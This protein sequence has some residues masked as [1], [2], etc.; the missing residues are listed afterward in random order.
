MINKKAF[1][2]VSI[3][4]DSIELC[5]KAS[6]AVAA[7]VDVEVQVGVPST[8]AFRDQG[9]TEIVIK[10]GYQPRLL[11]AAIN[12]DE[13]KKYSDIGLSRGIC[14]G[15]RC[16]TLKSTELV[17]DSWWRRRTKPETK[18]ICNGVRCDTLKSTEL[19]SDSWWRRRT[20]PETKP[21]ILILAD[22]HGRSFGE[23][24]R[25]LHRFRHYDITSFYILILADS[26]GRS[27]G[28]A[29]RGL[30]RFRHYD[31][32]SFYKPGADLEDVVSDLESLASDF[33]RDDCVVI[34]GGSNTNNA[35]KG[36]NFHEN[37]LLHLKRLSYVTN[38]IVV[39]TRE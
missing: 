15:V 39:S 28:E 38:V 7:A 26:H 20:K 32:T 23:A 10:C 29:V 37:R 5:D 8:N 1:S 27:F 14:N 21:R 24:V 31:I 25:G 11:N 16:D 3:Q 19:V 13:D 18:R 9:R 34:M 4:T 17:S 35:L 22:S 12:L 33:G 2:S 36:K 6:E 30:H